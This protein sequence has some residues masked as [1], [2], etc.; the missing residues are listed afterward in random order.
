MQP[1]ERKT[2]R[3]AISK[4]AQVPALNNKQFEEVATGILD[5]WESGRLKDLIHAMADHEALTAEGLVDLLVEAQALTA[6]Q[7]AEV[8][9][10]KLEIIKGLEAR[11]KAKELENAVR[12]YIAKHPWLT[13]P[14]Q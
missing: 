13:P 6:L 9:R 3:A 8:V 4:V 7:V 2:V 5:A 14:R 12:D 1:H 11:V 10:T